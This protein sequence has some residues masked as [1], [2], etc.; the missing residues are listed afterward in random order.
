MRAQYFNFVRKL[1]ANWGILAPNCVFFEE[2]FLTKRKF[3][4]RLKF[5]GEAF[6]P[7]T[8]LHAT[9]PLSARPLVAVIFSVT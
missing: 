1:L 3:P 4:E 2:N 9:M 6:A 8:L 5:R 7:L